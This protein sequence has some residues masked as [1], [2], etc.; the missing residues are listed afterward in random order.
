MILQQFWKSFILIVIQRDVSKRQC[1]FSNPPRDSLI[2][3]SAFSS[4]IRATGRSHQIRLKYLLAMGGWGG[5]WS[6][7]RR[8]RRANFFLKIWWSECVKSCGWSQPWKGRLCPKSRKVLVPLPPDIQLIKELAPRRTRQKIKW[9]VQ[10]CCQSEGFH[11]EPDI[12]L[13]L[14]RLMW[15]IRFQILNRQFK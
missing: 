8:R 11:T 10:E 5:W 2:R 4:F 1:D 15:H 14:L 9:D 6:S 3:A 7:G 13:P 12:L